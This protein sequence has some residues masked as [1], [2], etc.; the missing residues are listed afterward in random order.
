[1]TA[2]LSFFRTIAYEWQ[3]PY[4]GDVYFVSSRQFTDNGWGTP[5]PIPMRAAEFGPVR[6]RAFGVYSFRV[7]DPARFLRELVGTDGHFT[8][9]EITG[10]LK[11]KLTSSLADTLGKAGIAVLDLAAN[12]S[13]L[14]ETLR[15][16]MNPVLEESW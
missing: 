12:Y 4:K 15:D 7:S 11:K 2:I 5:A 14:G 9:D 6:L 8:T 1:N 16:R 10:Q 3:Q 13:E